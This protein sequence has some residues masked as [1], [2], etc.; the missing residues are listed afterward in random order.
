[1]IVVIDACFWWKFAFIF[2]CFFEAFICGIIPTIS[3]SCRENPKV[4]G[5]ANSFAAGVFLAIA[6][7]HILPEEEENWRDLHPT[8]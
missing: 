6:I 5:I 1:M 8:S 3:K 2:V 4:L 7:V